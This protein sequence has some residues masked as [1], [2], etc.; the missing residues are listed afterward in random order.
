MIQYSTTGIGSV[1]I[2]TD[3]LLF[4]SDTNIIYCIYPKTQQDFF[5]LR[6]HLKNIGVT[7]V[8]FCVLFVCKCVLY[9]CHW[10]STQLQLTNTSIYI[11]KHK[12][13]YALYRYFLEN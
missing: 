12:V 7:I 4:R 5:F 10:V 1:K 2:A 13:K 8:L 9:Y 11:I 3:K 6:H